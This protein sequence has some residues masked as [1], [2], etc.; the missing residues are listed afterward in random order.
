MPPSILILTKVSSFGY[1]TYSLADWCIARDENPT[2]IVTKNGMTWSFSLSLGPNY[3]TLEGNNDEILKTH[4]SP[5]RY[6]T[7][8][9]LNEYFSYHAWNPDVQ[10]TKCIFISRRSGFL[11]EI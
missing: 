6:G 8:H 3:P 9:M 11:N 2:S 7:T 4:I 1:V 10:V 5:A